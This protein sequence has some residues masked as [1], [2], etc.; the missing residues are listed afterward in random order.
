MSATGIT[1]GAGW[2]RRRVAIEA[3][4]YPDDG[5]GGAGRDWRRLADVWASIEAITGVAHASD[6]RAGQR[7]V[8]R[9]RLRWRRDLTSEMRLLVSGRVLRIAAVFD[10]DGRR[11]ILECRATEDGP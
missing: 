3:P 9:I 10:P 2:L 6:D 11:R 4:L 8:Y 5:I 1:G 7:I